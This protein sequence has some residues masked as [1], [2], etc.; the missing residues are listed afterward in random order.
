MT[1]NILS[2]LIFTPI[3]LAVP[4]L[5]FKNDKAKLIKIYALSVS[6]I[7]FGIAV[8]VLSLFQS[9]TFEFQLMEKHQWVKDYNIFYLLGIDGISARRRPSVLPHARAVR[10]LLVHA[11]AGAAAGDAVRAQRPC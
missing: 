5:F 10:V 6:V 1:N 3:V 9:S 4:L 7:V 11:A 2:I 8:Y